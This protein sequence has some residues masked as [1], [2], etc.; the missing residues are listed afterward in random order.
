MAKKIIIIGAGIGGLAAGCHALAMGWECDLFE[1][2]DKPGGLCTTWERNGY[3]FDGC[4]RYLLGSVKESRFYDEWKSLGALGSGVALRNSYLTYESGEGQPFVVYKK[5]PQL[6]DHIAALSPEDHDAAR[7]LV[8]SVDTIRQGIAAGDGT[9]RG[10]GDLMRRFAR[11]EES[12]NALTVEEYCRRFKHPAIQGGLRS[13][14]PPYYSAFS[15]LWMLSQ[16]SLGDGNWPL[17]GSLDLARSIEKKFIS[18]GGRLHYRNKA[19]K[20]M[21]RGNRACGI[22]LDDG[23]EVE[24]GAVV[25]AIDVHQTLFSLLDADRVPVRTRKWFETMR[26]VKPVVQVSLGIKGAGFDCPG[27]LLRE[28]DKPVNICGAEQRAIDLLCFH[29]DPSLARPGA[30][31]M[32]CLINTEYEFWRLMARDRTAYEEE[33]ERAAAWVINEVCMRVPAVRGCVETA[34]VATPVTYERM[35]G[36]WQGAYEGW[37]FNRAT[38]RVRFPRTLPDVKRLYLTGQWIKPGGGLIAAMTTGKETM[39]L[40]SKEEDGV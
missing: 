9:E 11:I 40:I 26:V 8:E 12:S 35:A 36:V 4:I 20:I 34:D 22:M 14:V 19:G 28:L 18:M 32:T 16:F 21:V 3:A 7:E 1:M 13:V 29:D 6:S 25:S 31:V 27:H 30:T 5:L 2:N 17:G 15:L 33:K 10:P 38:C 39:Q 37:D 24:G 23:T